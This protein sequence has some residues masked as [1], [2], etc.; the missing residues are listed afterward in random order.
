MARSFLE[1]ALA[2]AVPT[3]ATEWELQRRAYPAGTAPSTTDFLDALRAHVV[4]LLA[5]GRVAETTRLFYAIERLLG[6]ADPV[7]EELLTREFLARLARD[8]RVAGIET[9]RIGA[10]LGVKARRGW[11]G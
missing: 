9:E 4:G 2:G 6:D 5:A 10:Y 11:E 1:S 7:L 3:F 8:C